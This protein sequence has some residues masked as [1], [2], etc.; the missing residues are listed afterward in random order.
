MAAVTDSFN[1]SGQ[2][3]PFHSHP[4]RLLSSEARLEVLRQL[5]CD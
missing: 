1:S 5:R 4:C 3:G 2:D